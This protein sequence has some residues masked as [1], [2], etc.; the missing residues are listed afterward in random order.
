MGRQKDWFFNHTIILAELEDF[1]YDLYYDNGN[2][3]NQKWA[4]RIQKDEPNWLPGFYL[5][6]KNRFAFTPIHQ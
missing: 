2:K 1:L 5:K 4:H 3:F 6:N